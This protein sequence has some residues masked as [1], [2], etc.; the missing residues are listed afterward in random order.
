[1]LLTLALSGLVTLAAAPARAADDPARAPVATLSA[2]G[3]TVTG[4]GRTLTVSQTTGLD[5]GGQTLTVSGAGFHVDKGIYV[6]LCVLPATNAAPGPC[7]GGQDRTGTEGVSGWVSNNPPTYGVGLAQPYGP[8]GT[9]T[10]TMTAHPTINASLDCFSVRCAITT[11]NDHLRSSDRSQDLFI[12]ITFATA[13]PPSTL[14]P[15]GP[16]TTM[17]PATT[18]ASTDPTARAPRATVSTDGLSVTDGVRTLRASATRALDPTA[19]TVTVDGVGFDRTRG[20]FVGLCRIPE[21]GLA[22]GPCTT[23]PEGAAWLNDTPPAYG[24][25]VARPF[26][27]GGAF[28]VSLHVQAVI[29]AATDCRA[30]RCALAVRSDAMPGTDRSL[31]LLLPVSFTRET[32]TPSSTV[33]PAPQPTSPPRPHTDKDS[34][35]RGTFALLVGVGA[36]A[37]LAVGGMVIRRRG[38]RP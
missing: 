36:A 30:V 4:E 5:P 14:A 9:F 11:R 2:D 21:D 33:A 23:P 12:P 20:V 32:S 31:D 17:A 15:T 1:M 28:S 27:A 7:G 8:G 6:A 19:A 16:T 34:S 18:V 29:D 13:P 25:D 3:R 26:A 35:S 37:V 24:E 10:L 38:D 22:P